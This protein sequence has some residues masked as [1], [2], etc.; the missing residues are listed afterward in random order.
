MDREHTIFLFD[1][2][3][4]NTRGYFT[5][6]VRRVKMLARS[7]IWYRIT[8]F[9]FVTNSFHGV[10][11]FRILGQIYQ[12]I[13]QSIDRSINRSINQSINQSIDRSI[14]QSINQSIN[15]SIKKIN[16]FIF[17][18]SENYQL[19]TSGLLIGDP[20]K[21][22]EKICLTKYLITYSILKCLIL[23]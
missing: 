19:V 11:T 22:F 21:I 13:N 17:Q 6:C 10:V 12:S 4:D 14:D 5:S 2:M 9:W 15:Q 1:D 3:A 23:F 20:S 8:F 18:V 16:N 7:K